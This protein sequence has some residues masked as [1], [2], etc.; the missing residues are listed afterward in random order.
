MQRRPA[1]NVNVNA[2]LSYSFRLHQYQTV[3][4]SIC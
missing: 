4:R 1:E 2:S 3:L